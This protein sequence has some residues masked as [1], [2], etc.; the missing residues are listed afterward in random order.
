MENNMPSFALRLDLISE[1]ICI[2]PV[3]GDVD[4]LGCTIIDSENGVIFW[5]IPRLTASDANA[6]LD[7]I[8]PLAKV[9]ISQCRIDIDRSEESNIDSA[10]VAMTQISQHIQKLQFSAP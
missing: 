7:H 4:G 10:Y 8:T 6:L 2:S 1:S 5:E 3:E 9:I